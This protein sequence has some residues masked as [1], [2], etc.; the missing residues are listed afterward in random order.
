MAQVL[1]V[2]EGHHQAT[3]QATRHN[4]PPNLPGG[5]VALGKPGQH[6]DTVWITFWHAHEYSYG[7]KYIFTRYRAGLKPRGWIINP[8]LRVVEFNMELRSEHP[9]NGSAY[10]LYLLGAFSHNEHRIYRLLVT[11]PVRIWLL[12]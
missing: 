11:D 10:S 5:P 9:R 7:G 3:S 6:W 1:P 8:E 2:E 12:E 4:K